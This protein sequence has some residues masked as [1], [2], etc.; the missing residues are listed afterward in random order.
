[1]DYKLTIK[2][3]GPI[4]DAHQTKPLGRTGI[5]VVGVEAPAVVIDHQGRRVLIHVQRNDDLVRERMAD[6]IG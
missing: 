5:V 6:R 3:S 2:Q 1:M 4:I